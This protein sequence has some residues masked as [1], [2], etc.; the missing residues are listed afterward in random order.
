MVSGTYKGGKK[1]KD[2][3]QVRQATYMDANLFKKVV[4]YE[5]MDVTDKTGKDE[6]ANANEP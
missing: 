2:N 6:N 4:I 1:K 5:K 3:R